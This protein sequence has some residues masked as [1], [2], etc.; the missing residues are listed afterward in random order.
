MPRSNKFDLSTCSVILHPLVIKTPGMAKSKNPYIKRVYTGDLA[1][2][3]P[4]CPA[5][6]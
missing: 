5:I 2:A 4:D 1:V 3:H 6:R